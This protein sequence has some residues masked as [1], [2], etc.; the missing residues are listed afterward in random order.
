[1]QQKI[2]VPEQFDRVVL[3]RD[4]QARLVRLLGKRGCKREGE[5][6]VRPIVG[7]RRPVDFGEAPVASREREHVHLAI[8][9]ARKQQPS[10]GVK[11]DRRHGK[12]HVDHSVV[13]H[14]LARAQIVRLDVPVF[15]PHLKKRAR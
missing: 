3:G 4:E 12:A 1:M 13:I 9:C 6:R 10:Q 14:D 15:I 11:H 2:R 7:D 8:L 5:D